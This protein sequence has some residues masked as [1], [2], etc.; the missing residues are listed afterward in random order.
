MK[1][2]SNIDKLFTMIETVV[3]FGILMLALSAIFTTIA[4]SQ[5]RVIRAEKH[6]RQTH[7]LLQAAEY[8]LLTP[9]NSPLPPTLF[10]DND[11]QVSASYH[12]PDDLPSAVPDSNNGWRLIDMTITLHDNHNNRV[13]SITLERIIKSEDL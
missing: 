6:W 4:A 9:P 12:A 2:S 10:P 3:A 8:W 13:G 7:L 11:Y 5:Q 1:S